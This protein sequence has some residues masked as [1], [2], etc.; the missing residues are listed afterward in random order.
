MSRWAWPPLLAL[1]ITTCLLLLHGKG[2]LLADAA[3]CLDACL[4]GPIW[5]SWEGS[6]DATEEPA[7]ANKYAYLQ[8]R[9]CLCSDSVA[10]PVKLKHAVPSSELGSIGAH[11]LRYQSGTDGQDSTTDRNETD[12]VRHK[13]ASVD[14]FRRKC[15]NEYTLPLLA[16]KPRHIETVPSKALDYTGCRNASGARIRRKF[17]DPVRS[18]MLVKGSDVI[19]Y[20][21]AW[22]RNWERKSSQVYGHRR[23]AK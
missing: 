10:F 17:V 13:P 5:K 11:A 2:A 8:C 19:E 1:T 12:R 3:A 22:A 21:S 20:S 14:L 23:C 4:Q 6:A 18:S 7:S 16:V 9:D 15:P